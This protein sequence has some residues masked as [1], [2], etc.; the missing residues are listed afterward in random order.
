MVG[1]EVERGGE[2]FKLGLV[3]LE[4]AFEGVEFLGQ[5]NDAG[6][7]LAGLRIDEGGIG[8][9]GFL[10]FLGNAAKGNFFEAATA[11]GR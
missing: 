1:G 6:G 11:G 3:G 10:F 7:N 4:A 9:P 8:G 5:V 2:H